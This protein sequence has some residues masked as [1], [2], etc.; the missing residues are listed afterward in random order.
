MT[1]LGAKPNIPLAEGDV[2]Y[3][4]GDLEG[5]RPV[6]EKGGEYERND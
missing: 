4:P 3:V 2:I 5:T 6:R 1:S